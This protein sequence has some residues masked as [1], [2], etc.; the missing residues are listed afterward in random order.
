MRRIEAE[1]PEPHPVSLDDHLKG[2]ARL[3]AAA[4]LKKG[5]T[6]QA[7]G[8]TT[9]V[10]GRMRDLTIPGDRELGTT[11]YHARRPLF[12]TVTCRWDTSQRLP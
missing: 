3:A 2:K 7:P 1:E 5:E 12:M 6:R 9:A 4:D 10:G 8:D 11:W